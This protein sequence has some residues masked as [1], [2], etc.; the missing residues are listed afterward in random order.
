MKESDR[1]G[2][3]VENFRAEQ[4]SRVSGARVENRIAEYQETG[5]SS[6][7]QSKR[8]RESH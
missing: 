3:R 5:L 2:A 4:D 1:A 7:E 8:R 6:S